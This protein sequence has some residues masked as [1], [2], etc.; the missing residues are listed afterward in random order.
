MPVSTT[1]TVIGTVA[2]IGIVTASKINW[3]VFFKIFFCEFVGFFVS[4]AIS[5]IIYKFLAKIFTRGRFIA[6]ERNISLLVLFSGIFL[7][8][9][10]GANNIGNAMGLVVGKGIMTPFIAGLTG[11]IALAI[12]SSTLG[13]RV[14][15]TIGSGIV[16]MD[17]VTAFSSQFSAATIVYILALLGIPTSTTFAI[18]GGVTGAGLVKGIAAINKKTMKHILF[19][20]VVIPTLGIISS[21]LLFIIIS[22]AVGL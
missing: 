13:R 12:G 4:L 15:K 19:S 9:S 21:S 16:E 5:F 6:I 3:G 7:A 1:Q 22:R 17:P 18:V 2:G 14:I 20:W 10:L 11:G 8:Y